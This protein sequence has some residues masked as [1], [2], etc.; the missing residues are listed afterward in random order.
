MRAI[1]QIAWA[2]LSKRKM[3]SLLIGLTLVLAAF[4]LSSALGVMA[5]LRQPIE[6]MY[7]QQRGS[8]LLLQMNPGVHDPEAIGTWWKQQPEVNAVEVNPYMMV[9][10]RIGLRD[11]FHSMGDL[12]LTAYPQTERHQDQLV[13]VTGP[14][15]SSDAVP[16][17]GEIWLPTG[18]AYAWGI[19]TGDILTM[20]HAGES[21]E[22]EVGAIVIDPQFSSGMMNPV[23]L[24]VSQDT[25]DQFGWQDYAG[26][27]M[28]SI[29]FDDYSNYSRLW[30][31]FEQELGVPFMGFIY[32]YES[33]INS[34]N[35]IQS[36]IG[37]LLLIFALIILAVSIMVLIF[38][39]SQVILSEQA[40]IGIIKTQGFSVGQV[41][42]VYL[43]QYLLLAL[44]SIP[45]GLVLSRFAVQ[46]ITAGML[47][48]V[49]AAASAQPIWP[50]P[51]AGLIMFAV[52]AITSRI[53][54]GKAGRIRPVQAITDSAQPET[55]SR[56]ARRLPAANGLPLPLLLA[57]QQGCVQK[58]KMLFVGIAAMITTFV[59]VFSINT[60]N[61]VNRMHENL[62]FWGFDNSD[63]MISTD[64]QR[65][66]IPKQEL[67]AM[68]REDRRVD[69]VIPMGALINC[70]IPAQ[71]GKTSRNLIAFSYDGDMNDIGMINLTGN[72]PHALNEVSISRLVAEKYE[73]RPGDLI[74][75]TIDGNEAEFLV[76]GI[77]QT[78]NSM[79]WGFRMQEEAVR[80]Q[81]A[82][83]QPNSYLIRLADD[84][85]ADEYVQDMKLRFGESFNIR[86][87]EQGGEINLSGITANLALVTSLLSVLF[88][89][90]A[91][92]IIFNLSLLG[93]HQ[94]KKQ[95][96]IFKAIGMSTL[97]I[98]QILVWQAAIPGLIGM[99]AGALIALTLSGPMLSRLMSGMGLSRF[100]FLVDP[101]MT[102]LVLP[103]ALLILIL[104]AWIPSGHVL[105]ISTRR[106]IVE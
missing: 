90:A 95:F 32:D 38:T 91:F 41:N 36:I 14:K 64:R 89:A 21:I 20:P 83:Y 68:I 46:A 59:L 27:A 61:S 9:S 29:R 85:N 3:Q 56:R 8:H 62:A 48:S 84:A 80:T 99:A 19:E 10:E 13:F 76:T 65:Q 79:G 6:A 105:R 87:P 101:A 4:L 70:A 100:P 5:Q 55:I 75:L 18:Y 96:G 82:T 7:E 47:R 15:Q 11:D 98:R 51:A 50:L 54:S 103:I 24:W 37:I 1:V 78:M 12:L 22:L 44:L 45:V 40:I 43:L 26:Q 66:D 104:A 71:S 69:T 74:R 34:Y 35:M 31:D 53:G 49:G 106:L 25:L 102:L 30:Q 33:I 73:K 57:W 2:N 72:H 67:V 97:Q 42:A 86:T 23:R 93:I 16:E 81:S 52:V 94:H 17:T 88:L 58:R 92:V 60:W 77:Y 39:L 63:V 28:V